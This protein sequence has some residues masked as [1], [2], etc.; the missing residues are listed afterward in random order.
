MNA[1]VRSGN[2]PAN[3]LGLIH[4]CAEGWALYKMPNT[5]PWIN[6]KLVNQGRTVGGANYRLGWHVD[7]KRIASSK[8]RGRL[9]LARPGLLAWIEDVMR[10]LYPT[11]TDA[12]MALDLAAADSA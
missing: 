11:L 3:A 9:A 6:I 10:D 12:E 5:A 7:Q 1:R 8:D 2:K 4:I